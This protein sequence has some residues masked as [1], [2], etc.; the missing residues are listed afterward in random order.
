LEGPSAGPQIFCSRTGRYGAA[1]PGLITAIRTTAAGGIFHDFAELRC[2]RTGQAL[3]SQMRPKRSGQAGG[4][5]WRPRVV[6]MA[7]LTRLGYTDRSFLH[8]PPGSA[9][10]AL[11]RSTAERH[12]SGLRGG[13][14]LQPKHWMGL[15]GD[16][17]FGWPLVNFPV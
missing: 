7:I 9:D 4:T 14:R 6:S 5:R 3:R 12:R 15:D 16:G 1:L 11:H 13:A 10:P 2:H 8:G 17:R